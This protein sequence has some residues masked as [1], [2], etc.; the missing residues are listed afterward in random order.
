MLSGEDFGYLKDE[1]QNRLALIA[2][3]A[4][5][6]GSVLFSIACFVYITINAYYFAYHDKDSDIKVI[7]SPPEPIKVVEEEGEGTVVKDIDKTIYDN[8]VG[9]KNLAKENIDNVKIIEQARTPLAVR[10]TAIKYSAAEIVV[11][12]SA[13]KTAASNQPFA[14]E[15]T[16]NSKIMVYNGDTQNK[17]VND[18][19]LVAPKKEQLKNQTENKVT[20]VKPTKGLSRVQVAALTSKNVAMDYWLKLNKNYPNLL[21]NLNYFISEVNLGSKGTFYRLQIG[22]FRSQ[23]EAEDFCRRFISQAGRSKADCIIVE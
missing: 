19:S 13:N 20:E 16:D 3:K 7:K 15:K 14:P 8:I 4:L 9:N 5:L 11:D 12:N 22:N 10:S 6:L 1:E 21:S 2:K 17:K 18:A 23:V